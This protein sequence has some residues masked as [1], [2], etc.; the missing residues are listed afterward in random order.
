ML[1]RRRGVKL[2]SIAAAKDG[3]R[4]LEVTRGKQRFIGKEL[5]MRPASVNA[6]IKVEENKPLG[7]EQV[8]PIDEVFRWG[9]RNKAAA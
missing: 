2:L 7:A 1:Q 8:V 5:R 4:R 3:C 9:T 6:I